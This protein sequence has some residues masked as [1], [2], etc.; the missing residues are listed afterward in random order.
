MVD[1]CVMTVGENPITLSVVHSRGQRM[2]PLPS[3]GV[4][5]PTTIRRYLE[6]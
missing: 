1:H 5:S 3:G 6:M 2:L 4:K